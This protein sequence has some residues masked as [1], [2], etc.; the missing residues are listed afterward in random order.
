MKTFKA[1]KKQIQDCLGVWRKQRL[2][3]AH[4]NSQR[5]DKQTHDLF[6]GNGFIGVYVC[7]N[8]SNNTSNIAVY[9]ITIYNLLK[10]RNYKKQKKKF[11]KV[12]DY[13]N[14][15]LKIRAE[16]MFAFMISYLVKHL[17]E[18]NLENIHMHSYYSYC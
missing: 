1:R 16:M 5:L 4:G 18:P 13:F 8:L 3:R 7:Q 2:H 15:L 10:L 17:E 11:S 14:F 12:Q 6:Y 9:C